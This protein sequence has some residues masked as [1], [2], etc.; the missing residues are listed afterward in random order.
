[1]LRAAGGAMTLVIGGLQIACTPEVTARI[2][3]AQLSD[4]AIL[5]LV[6]I[7]QHILP[8]KSLHTTVF[9]DAMM[10]LADSVGD[11]A[12]RQQ[13]IVDGVAAL[14]A[15]SEW[16][17]ASDDDQLTALTAASESDFFRIVQ[18]ATL[19]NIYRDERAWQLVGYEGEAIKFGGY[20]DRGFNDIDWLPD[21][22]D[23][24]EAN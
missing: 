10:R 13:L 22:P 19:E 18:A 3:A 15:D 21:P 7:S 12:G 11:D 9:R 1:M 2:D 16:L 4:D 8:H 6:R 20:I 5:T 17:D 14:N 23:T 24:G